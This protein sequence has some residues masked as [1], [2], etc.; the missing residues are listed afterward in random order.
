MKNKTKKK[1]VKRVAIAFGALLIFIIAALAAIPYFFKDE[2]VAAVKDAANE[3]LNARVDFQGVD[4]SLLR[5]FPNVSLALDDFEITGVDEF[6]GVKLIGCKSFGVTLD[7]WSACNFGQVPLELKSI[8]LVRPAVN[9]IVLSDGRANY[10]IA[11]PSDDT[12]TAVAFEIKLQHYGIED[13]QLLYDDRQGGMYVKA[14]NLNHSGKGDFTQDVYD[15]VTSTSIDELTAESG[16]IPYLKKAKVALDAGIN[17]DMPN[18]KFTLRENELTINDL[19]AKADGWLAMPGDDIEMDLSF[20]TPQSDFKSLLSL[21]PN[22][23]I[24]GYEDVKATGTFQLAGKVKGTYSDSPEQYPA[25]NIDFAVKDGDVKYPGLPLGISGINT[26]VAVNSP[27]SDLDKMRVDVSTFRLKIGDNPLEGYFKLKTPMS[28][29][30][31]DTK[32]K[33]VLDLAA[34][35]KAFPMEGVTTLDGSISADVDV[36]A[37]MSTIDR[38]DYANVDMSGGA[39]AKDIN[40]V[41]EGM[42]PVKISTMQM[43]FTPQKVRIPE[44]A[45]QLGKSDLRGSATIGNVLAWFSPNATMK[46][47][48][49]LRSDYFNADE[50]MTEEET[51]AVTAPATTGAV[52]G[53]EEVFN[54]F[55]FYVDG[56]VKALDYDVY[57]LKNLAA[58]GSFTPDIFRMTNLSGSIGDSDFAASGEISNIWNYLFKEETLGGDLAL[59]SRYMNLNQFMTVDSAAATAATAEAAGPI[60]VPAN[61]NLRMN[62]NM[63]T[64]LYDNME[65][66][67]VK[68]DLLVADEQVRFNDVAA[69]TLGGSLSI[70]GGY[71]TRNHEKPKF[72]LAISL[73]QMDFQKA[74]NTFNTFQAVAPVGKWLQGAFDTE[75]KFSSDLTKDLMPDLATLNMDGMLHTLNGAIKGLG[76]LEQIGNKLNVEA[77]KSINLKDTKNWFTVKDGA[78]ELKEFDH[79]YQD[80]DM[81]IGGA[82]KI[83]G[84]MDYKILAKIPRD[85]IGKN[86]LGAAA[87]SGL[88]FLGKEASKAGLNLDAGEFVNVQ[89]NLTGSIKEPKLAFKVVGTGGQASLKSAVANKV[90]DEAK[91]QLDSV[92]TEVKSQL[93]KEKKK[94]EDAAAKVVQDAKK[95][96]NKKAGDATKKAGEEVKKNVKKEAKKK[97]K[98]LNPFKKKKKGGGK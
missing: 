76:P 72:D 84:G 40:Y 57:R 56:A 26:Q 33:G 1:L 27:S 92:K 79:K 43:D 22:A 17:M 80:I 2:I 75:F 71:D 8:E 38:G 23:Y 21:I 66:T 19:V 73:R 82:H 49:I 47:G 65:L 85:K 94:A 45:M 54:R 62:A 61:V 39:S 78:V 86:P 7:F 20:S 28:D 52:S 67:N 10:D 68:G 32:I 70:D 89:I 64:V 25:F 63:G 18:M 5:S 31:I 74:F 69:N 90:E 15:L 87:N 44:Y 3:N 53:D 6:E 24:K 88:E 81:K 96:L 50:W 77:L 60:L 83:T 12:T 95:D 48:L 4:I 42:P 51:T 97:I 58:K 11:K 14:V 46:G 93:D 16:G 59:R 98:D 29:P 34:L 35:G 30:D 36:K 13:G 9:V 37:R 55:V 41:A 91:K